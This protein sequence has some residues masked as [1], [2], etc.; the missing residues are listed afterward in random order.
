M[1]F[2][3]ALAAHLLLLAAVPLAAA[4][5]PLLTPQAGL[6]LLRNGQV[7]SGQITRAGDYY[8]VILGATGEIRLPVADV[9]AQC[10]SLEDA[11]TL[12]AARL[13]GTRAAEH[14]DLAEWCL[15][16]RMLAEAAEQVVAA[17]R[18]EPEN[19]RIKPIE[20]R[21][22]LAV[23]APPP[24]PP[25]AT[26]SAATVSAEQLDAAISALPRGSVE[27][28]GAI[29]QPI[30]QNRC[31]ANQCHGPNAKSS[32]TLLKPPAGQSANRRFTQRNLYATLQQIDQ[33]S[34]DSSP[35]LIMPQRRHGTA[36]SAVFDKHSQKQLDELTAWVRTAFAVQASAG[37]AT[38]PPAEPVTLSQPSASPAEQAAVQ[39]EQLAEQPTAGPTKINVMRPQT[40][41][42]DSPKARFVPRDPF[43]P[44]I[45]NRRYLGKE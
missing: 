5:D 6:L 11:Y 36:L 17:M 21:L 42:P 16:Q 34:P 22:E 20:R 10:A 32:F 13:S 4:A 7:V 27:K 26:I 19:A 43:D 18:L 38:I 33:S 14:L 28:F 37:P 24:P 25:K 45:F 41:S 31:G 29:V 35:L 44:E 12:Q 1:G 2:Y 15:R 40:T 3:R 9:T 8:I 23:A 39:T 30:L